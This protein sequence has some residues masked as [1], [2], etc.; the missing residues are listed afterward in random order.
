MFWQI[1]HNN[2]FITVPVFN[3]VSARVQRALDAKANTF[4]ITLNSDNVNFKVDDFIIIYFSNEPITRDDSERIM[5]GQIKEIEYDYTNAEQQVNIKGYDYSYLTLN[6]VAAQKFSISDGKTAPDMIKTLISL[7]TLSTDGTGESSISTDN[8]ATEPYHLDEFPV[9]SYTSD[10][11]KLLDVIQEISQPEYTGENKAYR[12]FLDI[13]DD[14]HWFHPD[15][16][17]IV[18]FTTAKPSTPGLLDYSFEK[19]TDDVVRAIFADCGRNLFAGTIL[20]YA[21]NPF[22]DGEGNTIKS[23]HDITDSLFTSEFRAGNLIEDETGQ[24]LKNGKSYS[25]SGYPL[26]TTWGDSVNDDNEYNDSFVEQAKKKA[27]ARM[28]AFFQKSGSGAWEGT[29]TYYETNIGPGDIIN[30]QF[31]RVNNELS[32]IDLRVVDVRHEMG[33]SNFIVIDLEEDEKIEQSQQL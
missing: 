8:V 5:T 3:V 2:G 21:I 9:A 17:D 15:N 23:Y 26:T 12:F 6:Q 24:F 19:N 25:A 33:Q 18:G 32:N 20:D 1:E 11:K 29:L 7:A 4:D 22:S 28:K 30:V 31:P 27:N 13:N 10:Y 16:T 14:F